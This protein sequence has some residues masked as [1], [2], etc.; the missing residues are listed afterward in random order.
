MNESNTNTAILL[1]HCPDRP[2]IVAAVTS[3]LSR[4]EG[5]VLYLD[6]H[7][8]REAGVFFMRLEWELD[9]F[10][11]PVE[12]LEQH[13]DPLVRQ[14]KMTW[15]LYLSDMKPRMAIFVSRI[16]HCLDDILARYQSGEWR[17]EI[18]LVISN[19]E[20]L[21]DTVRKFGP[22]FYYFPKHKENKAEQEQH[23]L[24]LLKEYSINFIVLARYMQ[25]LSNDFVSQYPNKIINIHHSF[26]PAFPGAKPYHSAYE[27]G[28]KIIGATSHYVTEDL[29]EGPIIDQ[30]VAR[31]THRDSVS[32]MVRIGR[33]LEKVVLARA[34][35][36]HLSRK[37]MVYK[38]KT[39]VF[40]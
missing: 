35:H 10:L 36:V 37:V 33:D 22:N 8:D 4:H 1:I 7:V 34:I 17:V 27:R 18:P 9:K 11:I 16:P 13:L 3:F 32:D 26:L 25:I 5:N 30:G 2:G 39:I 31:V 12:V 14:F 28:V 24:K 20:T 38:N 29:D 23:E 15:R 40:S 21:K 6:Q 19:H